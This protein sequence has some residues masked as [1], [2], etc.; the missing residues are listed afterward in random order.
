[1][2]MIFRICRRIFVG[3]V[4]I[5]NE[6]IYDENSLDKILDTHER[7]GQHTKSVP[8]KRNKTFKFNSVLFR[9]SMVA[10]FVK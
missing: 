8:K 10:S 1:M 5:D 9:Q 6:M 2:I 7:H 4:P 3:T